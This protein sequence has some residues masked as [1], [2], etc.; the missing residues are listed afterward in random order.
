VSVGDGHDVAATVSTNV[1]GSFVVAWQRSWDGQGSGVYARA[2][3]AAGAPLSPEIPVNSDTEGNEGTPAVALAGDGRFLVLWESLSGL[4]CQ[5]FTET[6]VRLGSEA[7]LDANGSRPTA[8]WSD[9]GYFVT[10]F[11]YYGEDIVARRLP[12]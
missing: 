6:G 9:R 12:V 11:F 2:F 4:S 3:N 10:V 5:L 8:A 1:P 7:Q